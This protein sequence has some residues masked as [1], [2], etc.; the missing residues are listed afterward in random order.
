MHLICTDCLET[1]KDNLDKCLI[2]NLVIDKK[3]INPSNSIYITN[4]LENQIIYCRN[5]SQG[6]E[7]SGKIS[8]YSSSHIE[9]S[10]DVLI[11]PN[12]DCNVILIREE[13]EEHKRIC[14]FREINCEKC[15]KSIIFNESKI[16][17]NTCPREEVPCSNL[18]GESIIRENFHN[19]LEFDCKYKLINCDFLQLGCLETFRKIDYEE[20]SNKY[21]E[22]HTKIVLDFLSKTFN[23]INSTLE[24][25]DNYCTKINNKKKYYQEIIEKV[26]TNYEFYFKKLE[27]EKNL[28]ILKIKNQEINYKK[29]DSNYNQEYQKTIEANIKSCSNTGCININSSYPG[30]E[31]EVINIHI[32]I[33][34]NNNSNNVLN[35]DNNKVPI[36]SLDFIRRDLNSI[37]RN[38]N[39][40]A[41]DHNTNNHLKYDL[42]KEEG[43]NGNTKNYNLLRK[44]VKSLKQQRLP[45]EKRLSDY[46]RFLEANKILKASD[47]KK[48]KTVQSLSFRKIE[49]NIIEKYHKEVDD[50]IENSKSD[51]KRR[52]MIFSKLGDKR[53][54]IDEL[55]NNYVNNN[56]GYKNFGLSLNSDERINVS[57]KVSPHIGRYEKRIKIPK[58]PKDPYEENFDRYKI[59]SKSVNKKQSPHYSKNFYHNESLCKN[60]SNKHNIKK[61]TL[62]DLHNE[63]FYKN[64]K[65][66]TY[67]NSKIKSSTNS[68]SEKD[69]NIKNN[70]Y[71]LINTNISNSII[72]N[73]KFS[74]NSDD[75]PESSKSSKIEEPLQALKRNNKIFMYSKQLSFQNNIIISEEFDNRDHLFFFIDDNEFSEKSKINLKI[76]NDPH[77]F[78]FGFCIKEI[79]IDGG[80]IFN[81]TLVNH[82]FFVISS[83]A[84]LFHSNSSFMNNI[85]LRNF[86]A[87]KLNDEISIY[88][89]PQKDE[90]IIKINNKLDFKINKVFK[91]QNS[92]TIVPCIIFQNKGE[93]IKLDYYKN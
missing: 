90:M 30:T 4:F 34:Q 36:N 47:F 2:C 45:I 12:N 58:Y 55:N 63:E 18:C 49:E 24:N 57:N 33:N 67:N 13:M 23:N 92:Q 26:K 19:H 41:E 9:C 52:E 69:K 64:T 44:K 31:N 3:K 38:D 21:V 86:P 27:N 32:N 17:S 88:F 16:H 25:L 54:T 43:K 46:E 77:S 11:C 50:I 91:L 8:S 82:G 71:S 60:N 89:Q 10:K 39:S 81:E 84:Y 62:L 80:L 56:I 70:L 85:K 51:K 15:D 1:K 22:I 5:K 76:L 78:A 35:F 73:S 72:N 74:K 48:N 40:D 83:D 37:L 75:T 68:S 61:K 79:V 14:I 66:I 20:H 65:S 29:E 28:E 42:N 59:S 87:L 6:C 7:Y 93:K 53:A